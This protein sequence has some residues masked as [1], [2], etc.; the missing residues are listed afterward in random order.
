MASRA[1]GRAPTSASKDTRATPCS[2]ICSPGSPSGCWPC[3][4]SAVS[5]R[6]KLAML[7]AVCAA[8]FVL[9]WL[10]YEYRWIP[11]KTANYGELIAPHPLAGPLAPLRGKWVFLTVDAAGCPAACAR[12][13]YE[14][15]QAQA[16][17]GKDAGR[18]KR[19]GAPSEGGKRPAQILAR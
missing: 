3:C 18:L 9:G 19:P 17:Q 6:R 1:T 14:V 12:K 15:R 10:A 11:G 4:R 16:G 5:P 8:P 7:F 2:G 13:P